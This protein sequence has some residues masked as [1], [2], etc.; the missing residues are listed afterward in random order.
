[1]S[2]LHNLKGTIVDSFYI[3]EGDESGKYVMLFK[4]RTRWYVYEL[5]GGCCSSSWIESTSNID[6]LLG[7]EIKEIDVPFMTNVWYGDNGLSAKEDSIGCLQIYSL[8]LRT[9]AGLF[10]IEFRNDSNGYYG[11]E[12]YL[13]KDL[14]TW[15]QIT[16]AYQNETFKII[17]EDF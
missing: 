1:M 3:S 13:R 17:T 9:D 16:A 7:Y 5:E 6:A 11:S 15:E 4:A 2:E 10:E 14:T 8:R 12:I